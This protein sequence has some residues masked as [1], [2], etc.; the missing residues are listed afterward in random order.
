MVPSVMEVASMEMDTTQQL[1]ADPLPFARS[2]QLEALDQAIRQNTIVFLETGAG[3]TLISIM[4]L[5]SYAFLLRKPSPFFA[6]FLVPQ[7]VLVKQQAEAVQMHTDLNVGMYW[8][9]MGTDYWDAAMWKQEIDKHEVLV[10]TPA[11]LLI[12]LRHSFFKL[13]MIKV[14]VFDE[15]HHARGKH[16]YA[17]IMTEFYHCQIKSGEPSLPRIFGM[18]ASPIKS[19]D[20]TCSYWQNI[21]ELE[22]L[23]NSKVYTCVSESV[24]AK[25]IPFSTPK[26]KIFKQKEIPFALY[27]HL[28]NQMEILKAKHARS[29]ESSD[30]NVSA[31]DSKIKKISKIYST[32]IYCL[33]EL[34]VWLALKAAESLSCYENDLFS[35]WKSDVSGESIVKNFSSEAIKVFA[36]YVPT[37]PG[38]FIG[39]NFKSNVD[40]GLLSTKVSCLVESLLEYSDLEHIRCIIFVE[41]VITAIVLQSLL[42]ELFSKRSSWKTEYVAG[43]NSGMQSQTRKNQNEIVEEFRKGMVNIIV[44]TSI[45]EEGLD[46]QSC[47]LVIRFDPSATICS[48][49][50][51]RGR[52]RMQNSDYLLMVKSEDMSTRFRLE[53]YINGGEVMRRESLRHASHPCSLLENE[54]SEEEYYRVESTGAIVTLSSSIG[55]IYFYCSRLP[56]D[57]YFK[58]APRCDI[59]EDSGVCTLQLPKSCP[60]K[61]VCVQGNPRTIK[62]SACLAACKQLHE[63]GALTDNLVPDIVIEETVEHEIDNEPYNDEQPLYYPPELVNLC[64]QKTVAMYYCYIIEL[65][66]NFDHDVLIHDIMLVTRSN[67]DSDTASTHFDMDV[68]RGLLS[69]ALKYVGEIYLS[70]DQVILCRRFQITVFRVLMDHSLNN[71]TEVLKGL[72][73][74]NNL[75]IDYLLLPSKAS[76]IDWKSVV[77]VSFSQEK[78]WQNHANCSFRGDAHVMQTKSGLVCTC[79]IQ[80]SLVYTPHNGQVYCLTG[81]LEDLDANSILRLR[82][83]TEISYKGYFRRHHIELCFDRQKLLNGRHIFTVQNYLDRYRQEK[84]KE[85]TNAYVELPP[86]LCCIFMSPISINT[87]YSFTFVPS[88]MHRLESLFIAVNLKKMLLDHCTQNVV[89]PTIKVLEAI[90]TKKCQEK[91]HLESLETLGDSFLKY[92]VSQHLFKTYV[93]HHEGLLSVKRERIISNA[94]LCKL[95]CYHKLQG[96][97]RNESFDPKSWMIPGDNSG[98][99]SL[100]EDLISETRKIY[101]SRSRRIKGKTVADVVE[102]LI[103]AFL[104]TGGEVASLLFMKRIGIEIDFIS[105]PSTRHF[106]VQAENLVNVRYLE[107]LL[108]YS[109][110]DPSLLVEALTHGS[111]ML[112]DIPSC[113]QRLEF[114]GDSV[115]DYLITMHLYSKYP[116]L[117][118]GMLTD[119][120]SASVNN[121]CYAQSAIKAELHKHILHASHELHKQ[122][123]ACV[124]NFKELSAELTFG[125]ESG[126]SFP[127]V[128]GDVIES[129]AGAILVDSDYNKEAVFQSMRPLLAPLI[130]LETMKHHP[131]K[132]LNDLCSKKHFHLKKP[133]FHKSHVSSITI[134]VE[135]NGAVYKHTSKA[136]DKKMAKKLACKEVLKALKESI[137]GL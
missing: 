93:N 28:A 55:L 127:K 112:P 27:A 19:K 132:E 51:S 85:T 94:T 97:I 81:I 10:M 123:V 7:V 45:L 125:W 84:G 130:T 118:P 134:E 33:D 42:H 80:N 101:V 58:P 18:T 133:V 37:G 105:I 87:F 70:S 114:L 40:A 49:I 71:L 77:S 61:H 30:L 68:G 95:G 83:G 8:G 111:Y 44:A 47:N 113:Y 9:E 131:V 67:L 122:I 63:I 13:S 23:M 100:T 109:F 38:W 11:I 72:K 104:S 50:Q 60:I 6:V 56:S 106:Q 62:Q 137:S 128:L 89:I 66:K 24:L 96:F 39:N 46:V 3:K 117:S 120:R 22:T 90:T 35:W 65:K 57:G 15:C 5:R 26:F 73:L 1:S 116:G 75:E 64:P 21:H 124:N 86:E 14:I 78:A 119:M 41:R 79:M 99:Y 82:N 53:K 29:L 129:L 115:L 20:S 126:T 12:G 121:D 69:V 16:P 76:H 136:A 107:S 92:V 59:D 135:A 52:A 54:I 74:G 110:R 98:I 31:E 32:F 108:N 4:L 36:A 102:A 34:G 17:C 48:F 91:F 43:N 25:Y 2:Y 103:G 88:I